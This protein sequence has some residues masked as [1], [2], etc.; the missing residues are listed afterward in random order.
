M[1]DDNPIKVTVDE[2]KKILD[3]KNFVGDP[4]ETEDKLLIPFFKWGFGFGAGEGK[5]PEGGGLGS[6][7]AA[8]VAPVSVL[9]VD[10]QTKGLEGVTVL[11]LS[12]KSDKNKVISDLGLAVTELVKELASKKENN[13]E[14]ET[15]SENNKDNQE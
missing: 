12:E 4:I 3:I 1:V 6:G 13:Q 9:V 11:N 14:E 10:K 15:D 2:L 8:G 5:S 7:G